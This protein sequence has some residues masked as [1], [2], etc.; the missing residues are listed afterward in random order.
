[1]NVSKISQLSDVVQESLKGQNQV[2]I[3]SYGLKIIVLSGIYFVTARWGLSLSPISGFATLVWPPAGIAL[4]S[5]LIL[6]RSV[7]PAIFLG[8]FITNASIGAAPLVALGIALGN[9]LEPLIGAQFLNRLGFQKKL[10]RVIDVLF[11][12]LWACLFSTLV[13]ASIGTL[14]L[15]IGGNI[16]F[17]AYPETWAAWWIGDGLGILVVAP[18]LLIWTHRPYFRIN[19]KTFIEAVILLAAFLLVGITVFSTN[20]ANKV[21][22]TSAYLVLPFLIWAS[23]R[24]SSRFVTALIVILSGMTVWAVKNGN[25][26]FIKGSFRENLLASQQFICVTAITFLFFSAAMSERREAQATARQLNDSMQK[27]LARRTNELHHEKELDR[28]RDEFVA[29]ASH[30]LKTPITSIKA[31]AQILEN[32]LPKMS[33][34]KTIQLAMR[35]NY[36]I[37]HLIRLVEDLVDVSKTVSGNLTL[38]KTIFDVDSLIKQIASDFQQTTSSHHI[39]KRGSTKQSIFADKNRIEQVVLNLLNNAVKYSPKSRTMTIKLAANKTYVII[40]IQDTG[41]GISRKDQSKIFDRFYRTADSDKKKEA[42]SGLGLG[43]Y[44]AQEIVK[45]HGGKIW[46][47]SMLGKGSTFSFRLPIHP[48]D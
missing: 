6:G 28:L 43:L 14:S 1:M 8:A 36:Q 7:W 41:P 48:I 4:V 19:L 3:F 22:I 39:V 16:T 21:I 18:F 26:P 40:S 47:T 13:S 44:I 38:H 23:F 12:V 9:T 2:T 33:A 46:V 27:A 35:I 24:Y 32:D 29:T 11:L 45:Q 17:G 30:E 42:V 37:D 34:K 25:G 15:L 20:P 5:I 10:D 31:Y